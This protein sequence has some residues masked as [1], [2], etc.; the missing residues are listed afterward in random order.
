MDTN[1]YFSLNH[2][3]APNL[4]FQN[5]FELS[6]KLNIQN[7]EIRN[8]LPKIFLDKTNPD[9]IKKLVDEYKINILAI[10][11][12]QKFNIWN[13]EREEELLF[14]CKFAKQCRSKSILLVPLNTGEFVNKIE[15]IELLNNSLENIHAILKDHDLFGYVEPLGFKI[16]SLRYKSEVVESLDKLS[17]NSNLRILHDT[18]HHHLAGEDI[19]YP[20]LTGLVHISG[21]AKTNIP[22]DKLTDDLR[23]LIDKDDVIQNV[24]Q[25]VRLKEGGYN[26]VFSF[27]PFS[28]KIHNL[29]DPAN[30]IIKSIDY[31]NKTC[32]LY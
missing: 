27:E 2:S 26:G 16:S 29:S 11:A 22:F 3:I 6:Q 30:E 18:F 13:K 15:R 28:E 32:S 4:S 10:N 8:D 21:V 7:V 20:D 1:N 17:S 31:L 9:E 5:F 12:L 23:V 19:I 24:E 14:L 25:I